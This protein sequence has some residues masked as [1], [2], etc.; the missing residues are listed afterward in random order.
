MDSAPLQLCTPEDNSPAALGAAQTY[1][2]L[3]V[4]KGYGNSWD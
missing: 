3:L 2:L 1:L 4:R